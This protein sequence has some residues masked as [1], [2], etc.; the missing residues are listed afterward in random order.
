ME[1]T[2][3]EEKAVAAFG[4]QEAVRLDGI[5]GKAGLIRQ[6]MLVNAAMDSLGICKVPALSLI[7]SY[8][9]VHEAELV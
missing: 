9:M 2:W 5:C 4:T 8:D 3:S 1:Y 6:V 7:G